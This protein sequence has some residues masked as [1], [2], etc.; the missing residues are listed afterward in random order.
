MIT[1]SLGKIARTALLAGAITLGVTTL[2]SAAP[3]ANADEAS[4]YQC[5]HDL[6]TTYNQGVYTCCAPN[7]GTVIAS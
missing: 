5:L 7:G 6:N 4:Y 1:E 2:V 3:A